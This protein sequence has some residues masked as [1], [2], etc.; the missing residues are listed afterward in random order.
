MRSDQDRIDVKSDVN[1]KVFIRCSGKAIYVIF[2]RQGDTR[3]RV[4]MTNI[5][6]R[7]TYHRKRV[8]GETELTPPKLDTG[9]IEVRLISGESLLEARQE[10]RGRKE[11][12]FKE[13][14]RVK[15]I[16]F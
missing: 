3:W 2:W 13:D 10:G 5:E 1:R 11:G 9:G 4:E 14:T 12:V 6:G 7:G 8:E 15:G 16:P